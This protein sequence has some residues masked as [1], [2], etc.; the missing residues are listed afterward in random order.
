[1]AQKTSPGT[2]SSEAVA[3][4][5]TDWMESLA[6]EDREGILADADGE[7]KF[8]LMSRTRNQTIGMSWSMFGTDLARTNRVFVSAC[9]CRYGL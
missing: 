6:A 5:R 4:S 1:M 9:L 8:L 7:N 3:E 2:P